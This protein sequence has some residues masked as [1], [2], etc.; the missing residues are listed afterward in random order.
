[1]DNSYDTMCSIFYRFVEFLRFVLTGVDTDDYFG[2]IRKQSAAEEK[3]KK[4]R[5]KLSIGTLAKFNL[6]SSFSAG[7]GCGEDKGRSPDRQKSTD[8]GDAVRYN[9]LSCNWA[10]TSTCFRQS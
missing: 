1:M 10:Q 8:S 3:A 9:V 2:T 6:S 5:R 7:D 4:D